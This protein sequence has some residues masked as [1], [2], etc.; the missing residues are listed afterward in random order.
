MENQSDWAVKILHGVDATQY[1]CPGVCGWNT[2]VNYIRGSYLNITRMCGFARKYN[3]IGVLNT[4][5]GDFGH[6]NQPVF[7][8]P[9]LIYGAVGSWSDRIPEY[10]ELNRQISVLEFGD[11]SGKLVDLLAQVNGRTVFSWYH[12]A[13]IKEW[14]WRGMEKEKIQKFFEEEDMTKAP[15]KNESLIA[16]EAELAKVSRSLDSRSRG[17]VE[18]AQVAMEAERIWNEVGLFLWKKKNGEAPDYGM[19]LASELERCLHYYQK[20]WRENSK[21]GD[22]MK[23][24]EV[25]FW[26]ADLLRG[27]GV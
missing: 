12:A 1:L 21:E 18:C 24:S 6:I 16:L 5:W 2:W 7:S 27:A 13:T 23:V 11:A 22:L 4:D 20:L 10:E 15:E 3:A 19:T 8:I 26:Y 9:G 17:I 25:F 14:A